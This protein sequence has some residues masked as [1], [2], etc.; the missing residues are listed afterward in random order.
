MHNQQE[1]KHNGCA[2]RRGQACET[3]FKGQESEDEEALSSDQE[4][5][6]SQGHRHLLLCVETKTV[7]F[8]DNQHNDKEL[9]DMIG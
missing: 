4:Q 5:Q 9:E 2:S 3:S 6:S 7:R 8:K 1:T